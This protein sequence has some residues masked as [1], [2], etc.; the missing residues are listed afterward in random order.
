MTVSVGYPGIRIPSIALINQFT[1][2]ILYFF[3]SPRTGLISNH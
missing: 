1:S 3:R 2:E